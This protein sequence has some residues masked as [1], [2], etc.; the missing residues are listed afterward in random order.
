[1]TMDIS[2]NALVICYTLGTDVT[3]ATVD[4]S[5]SVSETRLDA[6]NKKP[7]CKSI[8]KLQFY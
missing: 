8:L 1:M 5:L 6:K 4:R 2:T 7:F 3:R